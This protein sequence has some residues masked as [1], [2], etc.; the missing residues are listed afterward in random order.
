MTK[1]PLQVLKLVLVVIA[2]F[3]L[4]WSPQQ[5][6]MAHAIFS[7]DHQL[8]RNT[9]WIHMFAYSH[10]M[11][12]PIIYITFNENFKKAFKRFFLCSTEEISCEHSSKKITM[13]GNDK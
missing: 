6:L 2:T 12:N 10:A 7:T 11:I 13:K 3:F 9:F 5:L 8:T 4:C 1:I